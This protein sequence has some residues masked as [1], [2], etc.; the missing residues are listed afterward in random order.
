M[1]FTRGPAAWPWMRRLTSTFTTRSCSAGFPN[2]CGAIST[3][4]LETDWRFGLCISLDGFSGTKEDRMGRVALIT[5]AA[6]GIGRACAF[7]LSET[8]AGLS[9][10]DRDRKSTRL[11]SS[12]SQISYAG[13]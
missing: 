5:G 2:A 1:L 7:R 6:H 13:V 3:A 11:N 10:V 8:G 4:P 12:H 9:L